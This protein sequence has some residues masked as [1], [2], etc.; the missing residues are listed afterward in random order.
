MPKK[1]ILN[2]YTALEAGQSGG[3][4]QKAPALDVLKQAL[5]VV[6][7]IDPKL[8]DD[9]GPKDRLEEGVPAGTPEEDESSFESLKANIDAV[10]Q[11]V[12]ILV[13]TSKQDPERYEVIYGR[14]RWRACLDLGIPVKAN[15]KDLDDQTA[16]LAKAV[17]NTN[18][19]SLSFYEK[20]LFAQGIS[21]QFDTAGKI[22]KAIGVSRVTVQKL[23]KVTDSV[24]RNVGL[25]I[26]PAPKH[27]RR[28]WHDLAEAFEDG[29]ITEQQAVNLLEGISDLTSDQ[30]L[31]KLLEE[32]K[33]LTT[34]PKPRVQTQK[35][36][37]GISLKAT[38]DS[39]SITVKRAGAD[40][41]VASWLEKNINELI[42]QAHDEAS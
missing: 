41:V 12:P 34:E 23:K 8:I 32:I 25:L 29:K 4:K 39:V 27:G 31:P 18:R 9:W 17:E 35:L 30:K 13:R 21:G 36:T 38:E 28:Q 22:G 3:R 37:K 11:Q 5:N 15:I 24:P 2:A 1:T 14:R 26:G 7:E 10:G 19:R 40:E 16:L 42:K 6:E 20:A 33:K